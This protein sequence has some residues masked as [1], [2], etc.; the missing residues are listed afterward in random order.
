MYGFS[1]CSYLNFITIATGRV[2]DQLYILLISLIKCLYY[3]IFSVNLQL[4]HQYPH[5][6]ILNILSD[7]LPLIYKAQI[8]AWLNS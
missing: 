6:K 4:Q 8:V 7:I 5:E 2:L 3:Q 1:Q